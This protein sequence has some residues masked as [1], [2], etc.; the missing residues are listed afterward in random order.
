M[1]WVRLDDAFA[2]HPKVLP[3]GTTALAVHVWALCYCAKHLTDGR[4][5]LGMLWGCPWVSK[6][7]ALI[8]AVERLVGA[9]L[10]EWAEG[11]F[12]IHD[13][14]DHNPDAAQVKES[15]RLKA[16]R[17]ARWLARKKECE[18]GRRD[19][20]RKRT[21]DA[22][23]VGPPTPTPKG[24]GVEAPPLADASPSEEDIASRQCIVCN[25]N[26]VMLINHGGQW[27]CET[28]YEEEKAA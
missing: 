26:K 4:V 8:S 21:K 2:D 18:D 27:W 14:L 24:V 15:R 17:Q 1:S 20:S 10:W 13:Y 22:S 28:H 3:I 6:R 5:S 19:A 23:R 16:E 9:G 11:G 25:T 12:A 7:S